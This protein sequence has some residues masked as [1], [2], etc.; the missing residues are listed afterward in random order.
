MNIFN[1]IFV[2]VTL[3]IA[4]CMVPAYAQQNT[5]T[6][7][8]LSAAVNACTAGTSAGNCQLNIPLTSYTGVN[9]P[10]QPSATSDV[11]APS[12]NSFTWLYVDKE[13]MQVTRVV[14]IGSTTTVYVERGVNGSGGRAHASGA[15]VY[16]GP[17]NY[18]SSYDRFGSCT[19]ANEKVLPQI[20]TTDG[21]FFNCYAS[22]WY[23][24][25]EGTMNSVYG[26]NVSS[27]CTGTVGSAETEYLNGA[28]CS[29]ATTSTF[30]QVMTAPGVITG[31][32]VYSSAN[33]VGGS[34]KDVLTVYKNG[35]ATTITCT[36]AASAATCSDSTHS[37]AVAAGDVIAFKFVT[38]TSDTAAN[39]SA[40]VVKY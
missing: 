28:A 20:N 21:V 36:I 18:F 1:R 17:P 34:S 2:A 37:V 6:T 31:L 30:T 35:S 29:G 10:S 12:G 33:V 8:T 39:V 13:L 38:A 26:S 25:Q 19:A 11:G 3:L 4:L 22:Q 24:T 9:A 32:K 14:T 16:V 27:F 40:S 23:P 15:T 7:T 5:W